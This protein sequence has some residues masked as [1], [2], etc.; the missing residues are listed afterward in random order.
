MARP[1]E[2]L[3]ETFDVPAS[4]FH[5]APRYNIAPGQDALVVAA[6]R[7][8]RRMGLL[9]WGLVPSW[10]EGPG[11]RSI[12]ARGETVRSSAS[13][14]DAFAARR[15]LVPADGFYEWRGEGSGKV[16]YWFR[17]VDGSVLALAGIWERWAPPGHD[18]YH[19]FAVLTVESNDD[20]MEVHPRMPALLDPSVWDEWLSGDTPLDQVESL[21]APAPPG[22]LLRHVVSARVNATANDDPGLVESA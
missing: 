13:F 15:C 16:P 20:V 1:A 2:E 14:R 9:R 22:T 10:A 21:V 17:P 18:P 7:R 8:G 19:G 5:H 4:T 3:V 12:N 6:D 11:R